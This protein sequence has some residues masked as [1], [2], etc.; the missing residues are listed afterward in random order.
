VAEVKT[1]TVPLLSPLRSSKERAAPELEECWRDQCAISDSCFESF[2]CAWVPAP[3]PPVLENVLR[4]RAEVQVPW[5]EQPASAWERRRPDVRARTSLR[6]CDR[7]L[8]EM[9]RTLA[10]S[11]SL[12]GKELPEI[13]GREGLPGWQVLLLRLRR[14]Q[15]S[16][17]PVLPAREA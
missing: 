17:P 16:R 12:S 5:L 1:A 10:Q 3:T 8:Q 2:D 4:L 13:I 14:K 7:S 9:V 11:A 6:T 15:L